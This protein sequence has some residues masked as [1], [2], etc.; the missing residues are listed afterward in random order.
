MK[1]V[2]T[3]AAGFIGSHF[4]QL[5]AADPRNEIVGIDSFTDYYDKSLK[6]VNLS[7]IPRAKFVFLEKDLNLVNLPSVLDGADV[8][9]HLAGQPGVRKS[10]GVDFSDYVNNNIVATQKLLEAA[11]Q[12]KSV[13]KFVYASSSS[14]YG[15]AEAYP[16]VE[17]A[18][19]SPRSPY[20]A[21]K[22]AA[23]HLCG[24]YASSYG[25]PVVSLRYFTVFGPRQRPDMAFT[26]FC[27]A[28]ASGH[29]ITIY[30]SGEQIRDFTY[31][32]DVV[33]ANRLAMTADCEPGTVVNIAG[34]GNI[35]VNSTIELIESFAGV[36]VEVRRT[37][38]ARGDVYRTAAD[39]QAALDKLGWAAKVPVE[40]GLRLQY[41][42]ATESISF[43]A[44]AV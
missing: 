44:G 35:S 31:I 37:E 7:Y 12:T 19:P 20:G 34:G 16:T 28:A 29:P 22:L 30:G 18:L 23:E 3:G 40:T 17:T 15:D 2:V 14:V 38:A 32:D 27:R 4:C 43:R 42:W 26:R 21:T 13:R 24:I 8:V 1:V 25:L 39:T 6:Q 11:R 33:E 41:E 5:I 9:V 36:K 10:W